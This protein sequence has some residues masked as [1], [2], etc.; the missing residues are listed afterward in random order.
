MTETALNRV[1]ALTCLFEA[2]DDLWNV[3]RV[4]MAEAQ[5]TILV[6]LTNSVHVALLTDEESEVVAA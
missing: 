5:L 1:N 2:S 6:V 3:V 4:D